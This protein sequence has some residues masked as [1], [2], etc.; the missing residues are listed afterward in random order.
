[1]SQN[2]YSPDAFNTSSIVEAPRTSISA[3]ASLVTS[4][5]CC[6]PGAGILATL[7]GAIAIVRISSSGGRKSGRMLAFAGIVIGLLVTAIQVAV[8]IG[9]VQVVKNVNTNI[10][11]P[12]KTAFAE[13]EQGKLDGFQNLLDPAVLPADAKAKT[14]RF[15][16]DVTAEM[17]AFQGIPEQ[18]FQF[19]QRP[20][21]PGDTTV[22]YDF[23]AKFANGIA[24]M[25]LTVDPARIGEVAFGNATI[26]G[27]VKNI[28]FRTPS[29]KIISLIPPTTPT[30]PTTPAAPAAP[31][32]P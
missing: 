23:P 18:G 27:L 15:W 7:F 13:L 22:T 32:A 4:L 16:A 10:I 6:I 14:T 21:K 29:G 1:M 30:T 26:N 3:I 25:E 24:Q 20:V 17:G 11:A 12:M 5:I 8:L 2:P 9:A 31:S 19:Q 28:A